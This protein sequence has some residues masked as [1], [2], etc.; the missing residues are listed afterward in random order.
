MNNKRVPTIDGLAIDKAHKGGGLKSVVKS[1]SKAV[2]QTSSAVSGAGKTL[3]KVGAAAAG[4]VQ[5]PGTWAAYLINPALGG[6]VGGQGAVDNY[7][8]LNQ[9]E[10]DAARAAAQ[11]K[12]EAAKQRK[13]QLAQEKM[14]SDKAKGE[15]DKASERA[16]RLS[17][18]R[19]GLLYQGKEQG[20]TSNKSTVLGG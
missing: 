4:A 12:E 15:A 13:A 17:Q 14:A 3:S 8:A 1:V 11:A 2:K 5:D 18:G 7:N 19:R 10:K 6:A 9:A 20:V 16:Q